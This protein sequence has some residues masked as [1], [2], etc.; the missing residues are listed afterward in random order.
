MARSSK[1]TV[2]YTLT[3]ANASE[4]GDSVTEVAPD[5]GLEEAK[6]A[7]NDNNK[8]GNLNKLIGPFKY[9][10]DDK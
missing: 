4:Q 8:G 9:K 6:E 3:A 5:L 2:S 10:R 7:I 1:G